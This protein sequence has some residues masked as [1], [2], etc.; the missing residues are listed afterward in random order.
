MLMGLT[1]ASVTW[2]RFISHLFQNLLDQGVVVYLDDILIYTKQ[3]SEK[4]RQL[5]EEVL[6]R[7]IDNELYV[8]INKTEFHVQ[9]VEFLEHIVGI[10]GIRMD[11]EKV[12]AVRDWPTPQNVKDV[13]SFTGFCNYYRRYIREYRKIATPQ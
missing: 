10:N 3:D 8:D 1:N 12:R 4:H 11:Q 2:Q 13:Q 7:L 5:V 9:E 6:K